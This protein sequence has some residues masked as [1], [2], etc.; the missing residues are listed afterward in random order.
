MAKLKNAFFIGITAAIGLCT[1]LINTAAAE[2]KAATAKPA[3]RQQYHSRGSIH[4]DAVAKPERLHQS[5]NRSYQVRGVRYTPMTNVRQFT[6]TGR[7]SWYG[8]QFHGRLTASGERYDMN[9]MTAAHKTL[10]I[11]SYARVTNMQNGKSVIVR[12]NDRG[13]FHGNRVIDVSKA[14]A[15]QLG[16]INQGTAHVKVEQIVPGQSA[17]AY[18][19]QD[20]FVDLKSFGTEREAQAYMNQAAV[21]LSYGKMNPKVSMEKRDYEYVVKM[22]PFTSQERAAE[23]EAKARG[24]IQAASL[25]L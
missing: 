3:A 18:N 23:A 20:I 2:P 6:Q 8:R 25:S 13:P 5:A 10:P 15:Q 16:F 12:V 7:A 4:L 9:L 17:Q 1:A 22:G 21:N 11:P 19:G 24:L 14:A